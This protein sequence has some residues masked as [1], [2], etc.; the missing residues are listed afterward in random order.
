MSLI[1]MAKTEKK[2]YISPKYVGYFYRC[3]CG[4][5]LTGG[6]RGQDRCE[7]CGA[8]I[9]WE[10]TEPLGMDELEKRRR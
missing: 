6:Y 1:R 3:A 2:H 9:D 7:D 8:Y 4:N 10:K 5:H